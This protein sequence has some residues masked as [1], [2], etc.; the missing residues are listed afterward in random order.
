[1]CC[2]KGKDLDDFNFSQSWAIPLVDV[3]SYAFPL[4]RTIATLAKLS[5]AT[6]GH[7]L[8]ELEQRELSLEKQILKDVAEGNFQAPRGAG[9]RWNT[10]AQAMG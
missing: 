10:R 8:S 9:A 5:K 7:E 1:M 6:V 3:D 2:T 4:V